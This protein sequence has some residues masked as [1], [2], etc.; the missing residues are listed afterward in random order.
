MTN[1]TKQKTWR[2]EKYL[3]WVRTQ[4]SCISGMPA[5]DAH[6]IKGH[7]MG[8]TVKAPDWAV[9]PLTRGEHT[10]FHFHTVMD[11]ETINGP[12]FE[13]VARTLGRAIELGVLTI[14]GY[15]P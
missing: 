10:N 12:Q 9:I 8:G 11:W 5:D 3:A 4:P 14:K 2:N 15:E 13:H 6:H 1:L 7:G